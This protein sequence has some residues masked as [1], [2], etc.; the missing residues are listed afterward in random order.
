M[1]SRERTFF[2]RRGRR[3]QAGRTDNHHLTWRHHP[4]WRT[5]FGKGKRRGRRQAILTDQCPLTWLHHI[6][7]WRHHVARLWG[8]IVN[9]VQA[10]VDVLIWMIV[11][12]LEHAVRICGIVNVLSELVLQSVILL[13]WFQNIINWLFCYLHST[14]FTGNIMWNIWRLPTRRCFV[15]MQQTHTSCPLFQQDNFLYRLH[16]CG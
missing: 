14:F 8:T 15:C 4:S 5:F 10:L 7:W 16:F 1:H 11:M 9:F 3:G 2:K 13:A 6:T 12:F